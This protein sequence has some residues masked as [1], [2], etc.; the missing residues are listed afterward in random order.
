MILAGALVTGQRGADRS[1]FL[2]RAGKA[3]FEFE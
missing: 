1:I 3:G 2:F